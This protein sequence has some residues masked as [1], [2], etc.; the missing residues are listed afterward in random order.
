MYDDLNTISNEFTNF[1]SSTINN[2]EMNHGGYI[3]SFL[4]ITN[5]N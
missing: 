3:G 2:R 4:R 5:K 1:I